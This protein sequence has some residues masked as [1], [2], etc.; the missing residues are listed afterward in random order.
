VGGDRFS[1]FSGTDCL[2][3][4]PIDRRVCALSFR[5][6]NSPE[7]PKGY[8][9]QLWDGAYRLHMGLLEYLESRG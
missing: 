6:E 4:K 2:M 1:Q 3:C 5:N 9:I 8:N 7:F